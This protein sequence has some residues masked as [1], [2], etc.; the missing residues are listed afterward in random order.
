MNLA[1]RMLETQIKPTG[2]VA[3]RR[4]RLVVQAWCKRAMLDYVVAF[5]LEHL[6][7]DRLFPLHQGIEKL[8]KAYLLAKHAAEW[9]HLTSESERASWIEKFVKNGKHDL[10]VLVGRV[11]ESVTQVS[12]YV[13]GDREKN[14]LDLLSMAYEEARYPKPIGQSIWDKHGFPALISDRN[15]KQAYGL[16]SSMLNAV[17]SQFGISCPLDQP[18]D[19]GIELDDWRRFMNL[20]RA[21]N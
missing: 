14:F 13:S 10:W 21:K 20:R 17:E 3:Q 2:S 1:A 16:G 9:T 11:A 7:T 15:E 18:I 19:S 4:C 5:Q 6:V 12:G 8:C